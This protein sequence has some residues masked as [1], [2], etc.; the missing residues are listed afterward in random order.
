M[1]TYNSDQLF[2][3]TDTKVFTN[4]NITT[5]YI[6]FE[7]NDPKFKSNLLLRQPPTREDSHLPESGLTKDLTLG[8]YLT[9]ILSSLIKTAKH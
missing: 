1:G 8:L 7:E 3:V 9:K 4:D 6:E 2:K 5:F